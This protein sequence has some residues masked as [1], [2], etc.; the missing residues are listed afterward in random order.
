MFAGATAGIGLGTLTQFAKD[1][2]APIAFIIGRSKEKGREI[3]DQLKNINP[4]GTFYFIQA[5]FSLPYEVDRV[6]MEIKK[7]TTHVDILCLST[8]YLT[9]KRRKGS[10]F[11]PRN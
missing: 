8:G 3:V 11:S 2:N 5:Q 4:K 6:T 9:L 10:H 1:A 7:L